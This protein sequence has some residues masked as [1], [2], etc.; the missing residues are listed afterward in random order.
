MRGVSFKTMELCCHF[1]AGNLPSETNKVIFRLCGMLRRFNG[2]GRSK[3]TVD[4]R[5]DGWCGETRY[6]K[7]SEGSWIIDNFYLVQ[8][9]PANRSWRDAVVILIMKCGP[10]D[11]NEPFHWVDFVHLPDLRDVRSR[12]PVPS[13]GQRIRAPQGAERGHDHCFQ[14]EA[15]GP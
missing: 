3:L 8:Y 4:N 2:E 7:V 5:H 13:V 15:G 9:P 12:L 14:G 6:L 10:S 1:K 11:P